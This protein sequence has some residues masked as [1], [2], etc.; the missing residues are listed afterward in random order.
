MAQQHEQVMEERISNGLRMPSPP[1]VA[2]EGRIAAVRTGRSL[3]SEPLRSTISPQTAEF[4]PGSGI[5]GGG[6]GQYNGPVRDL[7]APQ[8]L[9][10][11]G[12]EFN[13]RESC[14]G[15]LLNYQL[16]PMG[17]DPQPGFDGSVTRISHQPRGASEAT[18]GGGFAYNVDQLLR[19]S[20]YSYLPCG[21]G[22]NERS[23]SRGRSYS[24]QSSR[25]P[26]IAAVRGFIPA[27][28]DYPTSPSNPFHAQHHRNIGSEPTPDPT[29]L[30]SARR[31]TY[32]NSFS[33]ALALEH[34]IRNVR[35]AEL[36]THRAHEL[37][38]A[39]RGAGT[40]SITGPHHPHLSLFNSFPV[41]YP[42]DICSDPIDNIVPTQDVHRQTHYNSYSRALALERDI[43][44]ERLAEL[45]SGDLA[46]DRQV[47]TEELAERK[48]RLMRQLED[49]YTQPSV[50]VAM[51][52]SD[53]DDDDDDNEDGSIPRPTRADKGKGK[54]R[55]HSPATNEQ[56]LHSPRTHR[57]LRR[58]A[59]NDWD[60]TSDIDL[61]TTD[62]PNVVHIPWPRRDPEVDRM[63]DSKVTE[64]RL[65]E[66]EGDECR[67]TELLGTMNIDDLHPERLSSGEWQ[68]AK[69]QRSE[70]R[71][72]D[73]GGALKQHLGEGEWK[74][75]RAAGRRGGVVMGTW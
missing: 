75:S 66:F 65:G 40:D 36:E 43:C 12:L 3:V 64:I 72:S 56:L 25:T 49:W 13:T 7:L 46:L 47:R 54:E 22:S 68:G 5:R 15:D 37:S 69:S 60:P 6:R 16:P 19:P 44:N 50:R 2:R 62:E 8:G 11:G 58:L 14:A 9:G 18:G 61:T 67:I 63:M 74:D 71:R 48:T 31:Q 35:L 20:P 57:R 70:G 55:A 30:Q 21:P 28:P 4:H 34:E 26:Q 32:P 27:A 10:G 1:P 33:R 38:S 52:P 17:L 73:M 29:L 42:R 41:Q 53:E 39:T 51:L 45:E 23:V 24:T 59:K